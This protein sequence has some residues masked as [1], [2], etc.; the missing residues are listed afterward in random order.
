MSNYKDYQEIRLDEHIQ[1]LAVG[2]V[3]SASDLFVGDY[4]CNTGTLK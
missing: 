4:W 3:R 2:N 1:K